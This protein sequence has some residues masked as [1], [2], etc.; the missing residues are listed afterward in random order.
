VRDHVRDAAISAG[1]GVL[2]AYL[3][4]IDSTHPGPK[5]S[6]VRYGALLG[7]FAYVFCAGLTHLFRKW[8]D[9]LPVPGWL[10]RAALYFVGGAAAFLLANFVVAE[11]GWVRFRS[12]FDALRA[13]V[14]VAGA[15]GVLVGLLFYTFGLLQQRLLKSVERLKEAEFA[16][17][18][19]ELARAIQQRILP[20]GEIS[21]DG[22]HIVAR[23]L[24]AR[25]VAGDFYDVFNLPDGGVVV[26]VADVAGKGI[27]A[28]LI[29]ATV[30][31]TLPFLAAGRPVEET[32]SEASRRLAPRLGKREFVA[33]VLAR[34]EPDTG[35][36]TLANA[37][38][39]DP[40]VVRADGSVSSI[41]V[42]GARFPLGVRADI[43]YSATSGALEKG[44]RLLLIS[45]GLPEAPVPGGDPLG[46][47]RLEKLVAGAASLDGLIAAV[48]AATEPTL[49]DD[50]TALV[51]ERR[52]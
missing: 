11:M 20:P 9:R 38:L 14:P 15:I 24:P 12:T 29:M 37:G 19:L 34:Y 45:D 48:R 47:E 30:K 10:S 2:V 21:A 33:L 41:V 52:A 4:T 39:P 26:V 46:Y 23:N 3:V 18:E 35:A 27:G 31:A 22:Y 40:Y 50:W 17:K 44:D 42:P 49:A 28:S 36:F 32:L 51:L 25:F 5:W 13:Y 43:V 7:F 8:L 1:V 6:V 16:E